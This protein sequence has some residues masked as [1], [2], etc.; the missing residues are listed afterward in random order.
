MYI[1]GHEKWVRI[2][3]LSHFWY[4]LVDHMSSHK[5]ELV[6]KP[7]KCLTFY[8]P[9]KHSELGIFLCY[10]YVRTLELPYFERQKLVPFLTAV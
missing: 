9:I 8:N 7:T 5:V 2:K 4:Q 10:T 6:V 1:F 3:Y